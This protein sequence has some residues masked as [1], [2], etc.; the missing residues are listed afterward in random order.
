MKGR[1]WRNTYHAKGCQKK[2]GVAILIA[3]KLDF[4][5]KTV[6]R[7]EEGHHIIIKDSIQQEDLTIVN[8][9]AP[10]LGAAKYINHLIILKETHQ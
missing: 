10:N 2:A 8:I 4:K 9:Y 5:P 1:G 3:D 7:N 6:T